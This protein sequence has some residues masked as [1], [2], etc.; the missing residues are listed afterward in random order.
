MKKVIYTESAPFPRG[1]YSQAI[2]AGGMLFVAG[3]V[4]L[5]PITGKMAEGGIEEQTA[6][7]LD[8]I[9]AILDAAGYRFGDVVKTTCLLSTMADFQ[10][11]NA[12]YARYFETD[13]PARVTFAVKE[14]PLNALVEIELIAAK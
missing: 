7:V 12:V 3:Q 4:P 1:P 11:M 6:R 9:G 2:E 5:D 14:L 8:N 13:P 10:A